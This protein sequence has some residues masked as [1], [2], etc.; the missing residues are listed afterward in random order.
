MVGYD[1]V[2]MTAAAPGTGKPIPLGTPAA[3]RPRA[4]SGAAD[5]SGVDALPDS[6]FFFCW[7]G[8]LRLALVFMVAPAPCPTV[9]AQSED[10][11]W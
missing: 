6:P 3:P 11:S 9:P 2:M 4:R 7:F 10:M 5:T 1:G 8:S